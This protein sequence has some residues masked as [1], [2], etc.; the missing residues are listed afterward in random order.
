MTLCYLLSST[1]SDGKYSLSVLINLHKHY[2]YVHLGIIV[3]PSYVMTVDRFIHVMV[4]RLV[5]RR[6]KQ[7]DVFVWFPVSFN[8]ILPDLSVRIIIC[9]YTGRSA[10]L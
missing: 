6:R 8:K 3:K 5:E 4:E 9:R 7:L 1:I 10:I 2:F